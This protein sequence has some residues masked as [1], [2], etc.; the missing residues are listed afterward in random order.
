MA[1]YKNIIYYIH[2]LVFFYTSNK[3]RSHISN[4]FY[5][6]HL[7]VINNIHKKKMMK[8]FTT[9]DHLVIISNTK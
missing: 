5:V 4:M 6:N 9:L 2:I 7:N 1:I 3:M 8:K